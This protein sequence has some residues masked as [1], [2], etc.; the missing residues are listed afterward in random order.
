MKHIFQKKLLTT[1]LSFATAGLFQLLAWLPW[2]IG[3]P[4]PLGNLLMVELEAGTRVEGHIRGAIGTA[5]DGA[6]SLTFL[7]ASL[8]CDVDAGAAVQ[9]LHIWMT[10][11]ASRIR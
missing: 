1:T 7:R 5:V 4:F 11:I 8:G 2:H 3:L 6:E 10:Y 9:C